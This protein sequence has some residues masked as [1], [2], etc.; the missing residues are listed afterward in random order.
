MSKSQ[1]ENI[2][3]AL[4]LIFNNFDVAYINQALDKSFV[5]E[6]LCLIPNENH[7]NYIEA[8]KF[9]LANIA[10]GYPHISLVKTSELKSLIDNISTQELALIKNRF[11][12]FFSDV[13]NDTSSTSSGHLKHRAYIY[14]RDMYRC[15][16]CNSPSNLTI[17][18]IVPAS[19]GGGDNIENLQTLCRSCNSSKGVKTIDYR[20]GA[21]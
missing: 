10:N 2:D 20:G 15:L 9:I 12:D 14:K 19:K 16:K 13:Y 18:H 6:I 3:L 5:K 7:Q 4:E 17:D 21:Q 1:D 11:A 8:C